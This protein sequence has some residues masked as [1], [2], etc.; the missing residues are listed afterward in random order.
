[1][2]VYYVLMFSFGNPHLSMGAKIRGD[3]VPV[4]RSP[5]DARVWE[6]G[7]DYYLVSAGDPPPRLL[8]RPVAVHSIM[9]LS[10]TTPSVTAPQFCI[11]CSTL[12]IAAR[13]RPVLELC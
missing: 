5:T 4:H 6:Y 7:D 11:A 10:G 12:A 13:K 3:S 8:L 9:T 2:Y 1:M